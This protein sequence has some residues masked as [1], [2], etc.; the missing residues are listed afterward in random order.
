MSQESGRVQKHGTELPKRTCPWSSEKKLFLNCSLTEV[1]VLAITSGRSFLS[2]RGGAQIG[3]V[4][5]HLVELPEPIL[6]LACVH[7]GVHHHPSV[8]T[9]LRLSTNQIFS[10]SSIEIRF[11]EKWSQHIRFEL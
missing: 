3:I 6:V 5:S 1:A 7:N 11:R 2:G 8:L 9:L 4:C 10:S